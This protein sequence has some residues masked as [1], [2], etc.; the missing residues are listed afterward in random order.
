MPADKGFKAFVWLTAAAPLLIFV[1]LYPRLQS[2][3]I[4]EWGLDGQA[5]WHAP[6]P[7]FGAFL[8]IELAAVW[9]VLQRDR[10]DS[11]A[12][13]LAIFVLVS[14]CSIAAVLANLR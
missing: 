10:R 5:N 1:V 12:A 8:L 6:R 9:L 11:K 13:I 7:V 4:M 3:M 14:L 2:S